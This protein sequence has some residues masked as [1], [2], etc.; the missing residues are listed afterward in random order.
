VSKRRPCRRVITCKETSQQQAQRSSG[1][2]QR[3]DR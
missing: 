1:P 3:D 2:Y